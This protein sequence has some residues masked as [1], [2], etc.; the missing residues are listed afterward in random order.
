MVMRGHRIDAWNPAAEKAFGWSSEQVTADDFELG[1]IFGPSL[2]TFLSLLESEGHGVVECDRVTPL[3]LDVTVR[4]MD[5]PNDDYSIVVMRD[6][7]A[8][9]RHLTSLLRLNEIARMVLSSAPLD[10]VLQ[11]IVD[12]AKDLTGAAF[13][14]LLILKEGSETET[15][16]FFYN[17][18]RELFPDRLPR[19]VGLLA[20]AIQTRTTV[21]LDDI[22]GHPSGRGIPGVHPPIGA[23]L[24]VPILIEDRVLGEI[25]VA[26]QPG[27]KSFDAVEESLLAELGL[28]AAE[29]IRNAAARDARAET[30]K[31]RETL[32]DV[33]R[34][35]L[36]APVAIAR[37]CVDQLGKE[38][39]LPEAERTRVVRALGRSV[40]ALERLSSNL[41]SDA[42]LENPALY[43]D[44][45]RIDVRALLDEMRSDLVDHA[46]QK[47]VHLRFD[48]DE[49]APEA[50]LGSVL[51]VRQAVENLIS[52]AIKY[53]PAG[54]DVIVTCRGEGDAVRFDVRDSG[55][56]IPLEEQERLFD[57]FT[58]V[59]GLPPMGGL[60]IGLSIVRRVAE[61]HGGTAGVAS[62]PG[63]GSTFWVS[64][65]LTPQP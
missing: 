8:E 21:R 12:E 49:D 36:A 55:P 6:V 28:H 3:T 35:D 46:T 40:A 50:L 62:R 63:E 48:V 34:H 51:L 37:G 9:H 53:S 16:R 65:P 56:G 15:E 57:R 64:F 52:N 30:E 17:A 59:P 7:T 39:R 23:L 54:E 44:F 26:N 45:D 14:G 4:T 58:R 61:S 43:R 33:V 31:V 22:R 19:A 47:G 42:R 27:E 38:P 60:G 1:S 32:V 2:E 13:S 10:L 18:P 25:A 29:A 24:A 41:R 20:V 11:R 5:P